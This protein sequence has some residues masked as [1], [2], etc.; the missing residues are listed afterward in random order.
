MKAVVYNKKAPERLVYQDAEKP[1]PDDD[2][3]LIRIQAVS[4]NAADYRSMQMGL[5]PKSK[6]FGADVAGCVEA[7]G[8]NVSAFKSG[9]LVVGDLSGCGFGGLAEYAVA[10]EKYL[11][12]KPPSLSMEAASSVP[13]AAVTALQALRNKGKVQAGQKVLV[14][15]AGGGVGSFAVQLAN[16]FGADV[17]AVC[18]PDNVEQMRS[19][20]ADH[21]ID[22]SKENFS[23]SDERYDLILGINGNYPLSDYQKVMKPKG[24]HVMIGGGMSQIFKAMVLGPFLSMGSRKIRMLAAKPNAED[25]IFILKLLDEGMI[26]TVIDKRYPLSR[27]A[28]AFTYLRR[29]HARGKVVISVAEGLSY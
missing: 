11:A 24:I 1:V 9:D 20:G 4:L 18:G 12:H 10:P 7:V 8:K 27:A 19:L 5:I 2:K 6:V 15:G 13:M 17:T 14:C 28:E 29:G 25:L 23:K 22:Y 3:V 26:T 21:V 16:Y